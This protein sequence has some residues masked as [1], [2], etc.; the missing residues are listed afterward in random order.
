MKEAVVADRHERCILSENVN[1]PLIVST[2]DDFLFMW[3][4]YHS[5]VPS[6][7]AGGIFHFS[8]WEE[9]QTLW[10]VTEGNNFYQMILYEV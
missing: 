10:I 8:L 9:V 3:I 7:V 5:F 2:G 6:S 4:L 1:Q